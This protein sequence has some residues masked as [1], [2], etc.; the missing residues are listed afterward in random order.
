MMMEEGDAGVMPEREEE[1]VDEEAG[2][3]GNEPGDAPCDQE[4]E[5]E[6]DDEEDVTTMRF[7]LEFL[8]SSG[9]CAALHTFL[10]IEFPPRVITSH[11]LCV[12]F[13]LIVFARRVSLSCEQ[14]TTGPRLR[15]STKLMHVSMRTRSPR[16]R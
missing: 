9:T 12:S 5:D 10:L 2:S 11:K 16:Q 4:D 1:L 7:I 15:F 3:E 14:A 13:V 6:K 8:H